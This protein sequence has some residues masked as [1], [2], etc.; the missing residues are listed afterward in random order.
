MDLKSSK[1]KKAISQLPVC[2]IILFLVFACEMKPVVRFGFETEFEKNSHGISI[3]HVNNKS[4]MVSLNG[5]IVAKEGEVKVELTNPAGDT[6]FTCHLISPENLRV[7][8]SFQ[9][10]S[11]NW[12]LKYRSIGGTGSLVLHLTHENQI[13][14][15]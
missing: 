14:Y 13:F 1:I 6:L 12:K 7:N 4:H 10:V 2:F 5:D 15:P 8:E 9:A 3:M 11:E